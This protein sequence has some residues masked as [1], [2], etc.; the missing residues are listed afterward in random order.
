MAYG[1]RHKIVSL[2]AARLTYLQE[3]YYS[4]VSWMRLDTAT[5]FWRLGI[6]ET[7]VVSATDLMPDQ[8]RNSV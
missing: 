4:F 7:K 3:N 2:L 1:N 8:V 5:E 6:E